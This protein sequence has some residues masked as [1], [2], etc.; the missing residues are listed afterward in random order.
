LTT[1]SSK[2]SLRSC[3][4]ALDVL[5]QVGNTGVASFWE[6]TLQSLFRRDRTGR[7]FFF[8]Q[9]LTSIK[10]DPQLGVV[11]MYGVRVINL[12]TLRGERG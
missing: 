8:S 2:N 10:N 6:E 11:K 3:H 1:L 5:R 4:K 9:Y 12:A 7:A